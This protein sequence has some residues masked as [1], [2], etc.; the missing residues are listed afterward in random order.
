MLAK[1]EA[2]YESVATHESAVIICFVQ[3]ANAREVADL[4]LDDDPVPMLLD[5][6]GREIERAQAAG[7]RRII[8]D[9]G[10]GFYYRNLEDSAD[11]V[12]HQM[13]VFL[14]TFRLRQLGWPVW[15]PCPMRLN[16][17]ARRFE[18][19]SRS[20]PCWQLWVRHLFPDA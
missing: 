13:K 17:L 20:L 8:I 5:Y 3:G 1:P 9:P 19:R 2:I 7:V 15:L 12:R 11:R 10:L 18:R 16:I 4:K 14:N 6:F